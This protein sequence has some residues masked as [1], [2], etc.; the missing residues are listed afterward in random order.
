M[1]RCDDERERKKFQRRFLRVEGIKPI[2]LIDS[3]LQKGLKKTHHDSTKLHARTRARIGETKNGFQ[4][5]FFPNEQQK[6][7]LKLDD[8]EGP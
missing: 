1:K 2:R 7:T 8:D 5:F 4:S 3:I 6:L